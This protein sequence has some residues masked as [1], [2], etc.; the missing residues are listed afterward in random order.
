[1]LI[2]FSGAQ[3]T[4][5]TTLL[6]HLQNLNP[7]IKFVPEVTRLVKRLYSLPINEDGNELTQVMIAAEHLKNALLQRD[8]DMY[9]LDRC[10]LDG[11]VYTYWLTDK[12][13]VSLNC[14]N[15][16]RWVFDQTK[17]YYDII[18]YTCPE[19]VSIENDGE[20]STDV[21]FRNEI[22][23]IFNKCINS[24][25]DLNIVYLR[26]NVEQRLTTIHETLMKK[27]IDINI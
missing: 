24:L 22:I 13:N 9:I 2:T 14:Y 25:Q 5:K 1:M 3:S 15:H 17:K 12:R 27:G 26:G 20:R 21:N 19:D 8:G 16:A 7:S 18:F 11:L 23:K 10:S 6:N 4:G